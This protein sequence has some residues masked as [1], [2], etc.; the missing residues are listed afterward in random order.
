MNYNITIKDFFIVYLRSF[1]YMNLLNEK[2]FQNFGF[3]YT[4]YP[5]VKKFKRNK[6]AVKLFIIKNFDYFNTNPYFVSFI[7]GVAI[8][9]IQENNDKKLKKFKFDFMSPLAAIGD[10]ISWGISRSFLILITAI[11]IFFDYYSGILIFLVFYN[12]ILNI[13]FRFMGLII[14]Y[15]SGLNVIF[16]IADMDLQ[17]KIAMIKKTG[18][19]IW[20]GSIFLLVKYKYKLI[21]FS[22]NNIN[23]NNIVIIGLMILIG[24]FLY[25]LNKIT[26]PVV[27]YIIYM[28]LIIFISIY[29]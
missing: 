4:L 29:K 1:L 12:I 24:F 14:G 22:F 21:D 3:L 11:F 17:N 13:F 9:L 20:G 15:K 25:K 5:I 23:I 27:T 10:A 19:I 18:L 6:A 26:I 7:Q 28:I 8:R 16:K 2:Y